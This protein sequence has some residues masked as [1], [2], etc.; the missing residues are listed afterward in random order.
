MS[1]FQKNLNRP[2][3]TK[4]LQTPLFI[5]AKRVQKKY[6]ILGAAPEPT[7]IKRRRLNPEATRDFIQFVLANFMQ[8]MCNCYLDWLGLFQ[9]SFH[10]LGCCLWCLEYENINWRKNSS[11]RHFDDRQ[12]QNRLTGKLGNLQNSNL[13]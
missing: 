8:V 6:G 12:D 11:A 5:Q 10:T 1:F 2:A 7:T 4:Y 3:Y 13:A 9:R